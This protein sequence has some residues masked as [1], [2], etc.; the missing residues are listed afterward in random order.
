MYSHTITYDVI[1]CIT[2]HDICINS[3]SCYSLSLSPYLSLSIHL[4]LSLYIYIYLYI[5][6]LVYIYIYIHIHIHYHYYYTLYTSGVIIQRACYAA[7][8]TSCIAV[9]VICCKPCAIDFVLR[10]LWSM[11]YRVSYH[12]EGV[13]LHARSRARTPGCS[14]TG[15]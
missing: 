2:H 14:R 13:R 6:I 8:S 12:T 15:I 10:S 5:S 3:I 7:C 11:V 1:S 4:S 9:Q